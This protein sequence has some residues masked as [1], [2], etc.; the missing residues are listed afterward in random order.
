[1]SNDFNEDFDSGYIDE[2]ES[3]YEEEQA[4]GSTG[5]P[6]LIALLALIGVFVIS[7]V[8]IMVVISSR[9]ASGEQDEA[10][11]AIEAT[12]AAIQETNIAVTAAIEATETARAELAAVQPTFTPEVENSP[13]PEEEPTET[14]VVD[15]ATPTTDAAEEAAGG[16]DEGEGGEEGEGEEGE[17]EE[18][19]ASGE[20]IL[21]ATATA[22]PTPIS[23][24]SG[25]KDSTLPETGLEVWGIALLGL[26]LIVTLFA[27]RRLRT[28]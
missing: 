4:S 24:A 28:G 3:Y 22:T 6:F 7:A 18:G 10:V 23:S 2:D 13:T 12:N 9:R 8:C 25:G 15:Q 14:P 26:V 16:E 19:E 1:M 21:G 5:Q 11:R 20:I 27:A 17:T